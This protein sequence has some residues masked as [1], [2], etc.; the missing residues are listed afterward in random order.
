MLK[1]FMIYFKNIWIILK[2]LIINLW[3]NNQT[4]NTKI[5]DIEIKIL[6]LKICIQYVYSISRYNFL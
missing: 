3:K 5:K 2:S 4:I 6:F 1:V